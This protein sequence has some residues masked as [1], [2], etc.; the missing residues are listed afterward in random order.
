MVVLLSSR[1]QK[2]K[3]INTERP[4]LR[5]RLSRCPRE[6]HV[7]RPFAPEIPAG[8]F[9]FAAGHCLT[10]RQSVGP[11]DPIG[12]SRAQCLQNGHEAHIAI[13]CV[14]TRTDDQR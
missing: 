8:D 5:G 10:A 4:E 7:K 3:A 14:E 12:H 6:R 13:D 9:A 2:I 1:W 11:F